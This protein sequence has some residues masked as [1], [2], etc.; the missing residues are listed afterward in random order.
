MKAYM[1]STC[2][3]QMY[4]K[5]N[6][7]QYM[8]FILTC[9]CIYIYMYVMNE[10]EREG[11]VGAFL[12]SMSNNLTIRQILPGVMG[13]LRG[14]ETQESPGGTWREGF[15]NPTCAKATVD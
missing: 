4:N 12:V 9:I 5:L 15:M 3:L 2:A 6:I 1:F 13:C 8:C 7:Y 11:C 10:S 14:L